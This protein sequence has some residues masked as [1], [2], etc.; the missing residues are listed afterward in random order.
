MNKDLFLKPHVL[1][2]S[3]LIVGFIGGVLGGAIRNQGSSALPVST[4]IEKSYVEESQSVDAI[5]KVSPAVVSIIA[6][7]DLKVYS[8]QNSPFFQSGGIPGFPGFQF[9]I[10]Q[11]NKPNNGNSNDYTVQ[12]QQVAGYSWQRRWPADARRRRRRR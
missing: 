3:A 7:R 8:G 4:T 5:K 1:I 11:Q 12:K 9:N 6:S 2:V 10:P